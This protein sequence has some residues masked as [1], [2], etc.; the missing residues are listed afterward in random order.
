MGHG[1]LPGVLP[2]EVLSASNRTPEPLLRHQNGERR[3]F[4]LSATFEPFP[5]LKLGPFKLS[6]YQI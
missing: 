2:V 3:I 4:G 6:P 1:V 5:L